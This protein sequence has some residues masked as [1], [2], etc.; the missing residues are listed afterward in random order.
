[1]GWE[2]GG[3]VLWLFNDIWFSLRAVHYNFNTFAFSSSFN[4]EDSLP[5]GTARLYLQVGWCCVAT[6]LQ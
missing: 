6:F 3:W 5:N 4:L 1:L 2:K